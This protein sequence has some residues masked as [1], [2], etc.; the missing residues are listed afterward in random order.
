VLCGN[1]SSYEASATSLVCIEHTALRFRLCA[2]STPLCEHFVLRAA[3]K[4]FVW[5]WGGPKHQAAYSLQSPLCV[6][7]V[8]VVA[9]SHAILF[10]F[11]DCLPPAVLHQH[12]TCKC[13]SKQPSEYAASTREYAVSR[14]K[15]YFVSGF[16]FF[17]IF[18]FFLKCCSIAL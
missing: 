1:D 11:D 14:K 6:S 12:K 5:P 7:K 8:I 9:L 18:W 16:V 10:G 4:F 13:C 3:L 17:V 15:F 2:L